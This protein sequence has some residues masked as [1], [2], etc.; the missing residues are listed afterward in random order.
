MQRI[1][2]T[3]DYEVKQGRFLILSTLS[4]DRYIEVAADIID[5]TDQAY[6]IA[7]RLQGSNSHLK[8]D[9]TFWIHEGFIIA[10]SKDSHE[11]AEALSV[12][13]RAEANEVLTD[14]LADMNAYQA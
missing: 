8:G 3:A 1:F 2:T 11:C 14:F 13:T 5:G 4:G 10:H 7:V 6:Q 9:D 12:K